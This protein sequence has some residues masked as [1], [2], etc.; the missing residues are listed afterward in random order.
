MS[1]NGPAKRACPSAD[2]AASDA[3]PYATQAYVQEACELS[4]TSMGD[5][6]KATFAKSM[7][8]VMEQFNQSMGE[9]VEETKMELGTRIGKVEQRVGNLEDTSVALKHAHSEQAS[10]IKQ[11]YARTESL[12]KQLVIANQSHVSREDIESNQFDRPANKE[13]IKIHA[14]RYVTKASVLLAIEP[15][16]RESGIN[17]D[18]FTLVGHAPAGKRFTI[19]FPFNPLSAARLAQDAM[20][21]LKDDDENWKVFHAQLVNGA[22]EKLHIG[23]DENDRTRTIR[24][25][26]A[27]FK[28]ACHELYPHI[29]NVHFR[30]YKEAV[31]ADKLA[32]CKF[33]PVSKTPQTDHF[34][35]DFDSLEELSISKPNLLNKTLE[36]LQRPEDNT[37]WRL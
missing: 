13:I 15:W 6:T 9:A 28:K 2:A 32:L 10:D 31:Y 7:A 8:N 35:W 36:L 20:D 1:A 3:N 5:K 14:H 24:R 16:L 30:S 17:P 26:A 34:L 19:K 29:E 25:M 37:Q 27:V 22:Q 12:E 23:S 11:L 33:E 18:Q 4:A 21:N